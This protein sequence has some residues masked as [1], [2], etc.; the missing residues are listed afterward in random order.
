MEEIKYAIGNILQRNIAI[1]FQQ[2][3]EIKQ[4][5]LKARNIV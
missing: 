4:L 1:F 2:F 3:Y 5:V